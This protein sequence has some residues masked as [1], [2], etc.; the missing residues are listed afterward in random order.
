MCLCS[1]GGCNCPALAPLPPQREPCCA[2]QEM[3]NM[4][5]IILQLYHSQTFLVSYNIIISFVEIESTCGFKALPE[6]ACT[7]LRG[8]VPQQNHP[9]P[10]SWSG[11]RKPLL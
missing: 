3:Y 1:H 5:I 6:E 10:A 7:S 2:S 4:I 8:E 9:G 11:A